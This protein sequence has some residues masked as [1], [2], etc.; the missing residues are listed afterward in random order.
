MK[1]RVHVKKENCE[2][3]T[4]NEKL[5][6]NNAVTTEKRPTPTDKTREL[7]G[8]TSEEVPE[9]TQVSWRMDI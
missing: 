1:P 8:I 5:K 7:T 9:K 2:K 6:T 4:K 3:A